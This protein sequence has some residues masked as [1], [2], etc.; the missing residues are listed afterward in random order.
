MKAARVHTPAIRRYGKRF[1]VQGPPVIQIDL[2]QASSN[3]SSFCYQS[4]K[5]LRH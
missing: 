3:D 4:K 5:T 1:D 2:S